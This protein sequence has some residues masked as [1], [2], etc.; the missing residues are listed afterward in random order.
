MIRHLGIGVLVPFLASC[1]YRHVRADSSLCGV[2]RCSADVLWGSVGSDADRSKPH[3]MSFDVVNSRAMNLDAD[4]QGEWDRECQ[5]SAVSRS[6]TARHRP[7]A[8]R[9]RRMARVAEAQP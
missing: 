8:S 6:A 2:A 3:M 4:P 7:A 1:M 5:G 9:R